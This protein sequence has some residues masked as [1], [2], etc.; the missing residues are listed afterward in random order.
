MT[1]ATGYLRKMLQNILNLLSNERPSQPYLP[2][3]KTSRYLLITLRGMA[4]GVTSEK[5]HGEDG[6][7]PDQDQPTLSAQSCFIR[8]LRSVLDT[9]LSCTSFHVEELSREMG[10]SRVHLYRKMKAACGQ[11]PSEYIRNYRLLYAMRLL[12]SDAVSVS[13]AAYHSGFNDLSHFS[14]C[15]KRAFGMSPSHYQKYSYEYTEAL[16]GVDQPGQGHKE[17]LNFSN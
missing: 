17:R 11:S 1:N 7:V 16:S 8:K 13:E 5:P 14:K 2:V 6:P 10:L 9:H 4:P 15:F 3:G 12:R